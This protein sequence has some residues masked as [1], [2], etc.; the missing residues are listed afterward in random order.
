M[1]IVK[2]ELIG[3]TNVVF[4]FLTLFLF[5]ILICSKKLQFILFIPYISF[6]IP[7]KQQKTLRSSDV[8]EMKQEQIS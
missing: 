7:G 6:C 1:F 5:L 3:N 4:L 8:E 2:L